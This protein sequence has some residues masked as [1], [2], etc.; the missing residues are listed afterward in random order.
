MC[1]TYTEKA[2]KTAPEKREMK[3]VEPPFPSRDELID[4]FFPELGSINSFYGIV[5]VEDG[6]YYRYEMVKSNSMPMQ[7][8]IKK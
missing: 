4:P 5:P 8:F 1:T 7:V 2:Y 3:P 6:N